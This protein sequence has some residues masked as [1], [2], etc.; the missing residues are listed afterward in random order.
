MTLPTHIVAGLIVGKIT[1]DYALGIS[2]SLLVDIDHLQSYIKSGVIL[3]PKLFWKTI[4]DKSDPYG[5]Q[6]GYLHNLLVF[7][8]IS[9]ILLLSFGYIVLPL[10]AGWLGHLLLDAL[11]NSDYWPFYPYKQLN[12][13]GHIK[14]ASVQEAMFLFFLLIIYFII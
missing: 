10:V 2:S 14:Y 7:L 11:D 5:D 13:R 9:I 3:R 4:T 6:R 12:L 1:G 8:G